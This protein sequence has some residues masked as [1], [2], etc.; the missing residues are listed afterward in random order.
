[1]A[2][3]DWG[4][5]LKDYCKQMHINH[6]PTAVVNRLLDDHKKGL[7]NDVQESWITSFFEEV[8]G[9]L[10]RKQ[11][12]VIDS[13]CITDGEL[14]KIYE[15]FAVAMSGMKSASGLYDKVK[16]TDA[17]NF[18]KEYFDTKQVF[19]TPKATPETATSIENIVNFLQNGSQEAAKFKNDLLNI[20]KIDSN[21][22]LTNDPLFAQ[23]SDVEKLLTKCKNGEYNTN[24][25]VQNKI[26]RI[27]RHLNGELSE[28]SYGEDPNKE[29]LS[30]IRTDLQNVSNADAFSQIDFPTD[31]HGNPL[32]D[33]ETFGREHLPNLLQTL[34]ENKDI[35]AKFADKD[36][37]DILGK[38]IKKAEKLAWNDS[39]SADYVKPKY[40]DVRTPLQQLEKWAGDTYNDTLK[41]YEELRGAHLFSSPFAKEICK[42]IDKVKI[43]PAD[44]LD[45]LLEK[46]AD[47][48]GKI[49]NKN[50][51]SHF[52]WFVDT[53]NEVKGDISNAIK[54]CWNNAEQMHCVIEKIILKA[55]E[56]G[57]TAEDIE[58]AKTAMEIMTVMKYG[59]MTSKI[60]D[61]MRQEEFSMFSDGKLSWNK[62]EGI[63]FV[64]K[65]FDKS[66]KAAFLGV[67]YGIT[68]AR[69]KIM[70]RGMKFSD[71]HNE[72]GL[73]AERKKELD[74]KQAQYDA[75]KQAMIN[76]D[77]RDEA[78]I[79]THEATIASLE[80]T[81][82]AD[83]AY[84]ETVEADLKRI[85]EQIQEKNK[86]IRKLE[87]EIETAEQ[88]QQS[89]EQAFQKQS[90]YKEAF[91]KAND[92]IA[93]RDLD[94]EKIKIDKRDAETRNSLAEID[95]ILSHTPL[96][97]PDNNP[98]TDPDTEE[99]YRKK[100]AAD[101]ADLFTQRTE[102]KKS[103][104]QNADDRNPATMSAE[105][106]DKLNNANNT[107]NDFINNH[108][109]D[110]NNAQTNLNNKNAELNTKQT[111]L[112]TAQAELQTLTNEHQTKSSDAAYR[113]ASTKVNQYD[114][115]TKKLKELNKVHEEREKALS[116]WDQDHVNKVLYLENYWNMLN[117]NESKTW[118]LFT[119][120]QQKSFDAT[121]SERMRRM[122]LATQNGHLIP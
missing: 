55:T 75:D 105:R 122:L 113:T 51:A 94:Q 21:G 103:L 72:S 23:P 69:N 49:D 84:K 64:T 90:Q 115:A 24:T 41:K 81:Y 19:T 10:V 29:A 65:A 1:M 111:E 42:A 3:T 28:F 83:K 100:L 117:G 13:S 32:M 87:E 47:I 61:A 46:S 34:Y 7:L 107:K 62:N 106:R 25:T 15:A 12:P 16:D 8:D 93:N 116:T 99:A 80:P 59:M 102:I 39:N 18:V 43:K 104:K 20:K 88:N 60:M 11:L 36:E 96:L 14:K 27:A 48:K 31:E 89:A 86:Q 112:A 4:N 2:Y 6:M 97:D 52:D 40:D 37:K 95:A 26:Q 56:P 22:Q 76:A 38:G 108:Q 67:G 54:G 17:I 91:D 35:R 68:I 79:T 78:D 57:K 92:I 120:D 45:K 110:Y 44:G 73:L 66:I 33:L 98:I 82:A 121:K 63:Q 5:F 118:R 114:D 71:K 30:K 101:R 58:K 9:K 85:N 74:G 50:V 119:N 77:A 70:M 53:M 109:T